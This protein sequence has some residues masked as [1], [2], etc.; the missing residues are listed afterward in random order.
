MSNNSFDEIYR[1]SLKTS[2]I[3]EEFERKHKRELNRKLE[4]TKFTSLILS[5]IVT[6]G[7]L[8]GGI[9]LAN[10]NTK[11]VPVDPVLTQHVDVIDAFK[12]K[13][14]EIRNS[15]VN[16][17]NISFMLGELAYK[18]HDKLLYNVR[19]SVTGGEEYKHDLTANAIIK[20]EKMFEDNNID[21]L[22]TKFDFIYY[23]ARND[24][25]A[26]KYNKVSHDMT[27]EEILFLDVLQLIRTGDFDEARKDMFKDVTSFDDY[28][29]MKGYVDKDGKPSRKIYEDKM[30]ELVNE[31]YQEIS[32]YKEVTK[33]GSL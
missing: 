7:I 25:G 21:G 29:V 17:E 14:S 22:G 8:A 15:E 16:E 28:L 10:L 23:I 26:N 27:N 18:E 30:H 4:R 5:V 20:L 32:N 1:R 13:I 3:E 33:N 2:L 31:M 6:A 12:G 19:N 9:S 24:M 11:N